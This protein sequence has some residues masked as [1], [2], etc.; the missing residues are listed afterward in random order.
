MGS[1]VLP[2]ASS[3]VVISS[4]NC[5]PFVAA[6]FSP[7]SGFPGFAPFRLSQRHELVKTKPKQLHLFLNTNNSGDNIDEDE[8]H[9]DLEKAREHLESLLLGDDSSAYSTAESFLEA[10]KG[11]RA[12]RGHHTATVRAPSYSS[13]LAPPLPPLDVVLPP[14]PPLTTIERERRETEIQL[15]SHLAQGDEAV[16]DLWTLW[17]SEK[18]RDTAQRLVRAEELTG[19]GGSL[20]WSHAEDIL[21][22]LV[23]EHG[24]YWVEPLNR[25]ATLYYMQGRL[26]EAETLCKIVLAIKPWHFGALS[27]IVM[28]FAAQT[29]SEKA[30]LWAACR[31]PM[32]APT[33][34]N[35][36]RIAWTEQAV[37]SAQESLDAAEI[38]VQELFGEPDDYRDAAS[39]P[40]RD[41]DDAWKDVGDAWQ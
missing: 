28:I 40:S 11:V 32:F 36:R 31:L 27:G 37:L 15:L 30:R 6:A 16:N 4:L 7:A 2:L 8:G 13:D 34:A 41:L 38:R 23:E 19:E 12:S 9:F 10:Q 20:A 25:L 39:R 5:V 24:V 18:G 29:N 14:A 22:A 1:I 26:D 17:Y 35:R 21:R 3:F 33:G